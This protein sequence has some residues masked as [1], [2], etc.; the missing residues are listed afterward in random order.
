MTED[1][2]AMIREL[3]SNL[4]TYS[5]MGERQLSDCGYDLEDLLAWGRTLADVVA[6]T[7]PELD[8]PGEGYL[9]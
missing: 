5:G 4:R 6:D 8:A 1:K 7:F 3:I 9:A 2:K